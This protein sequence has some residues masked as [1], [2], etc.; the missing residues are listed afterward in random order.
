MDFNGSKKDKN[1]YSW[2]AWRHP[3]FLMC[4]ILP[5]CTSKTLLKMRKLPGDKARICYAGGP[6]FLNNFFLPS[7]KTYAA[8]QADFA[9]TNSYKAFPGI[10][11]GNLLIQSQYPADFRIFLQNRADI[12]A[13]CRQVIP[14]R[15]LLAL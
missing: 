14:P 8:R 7:R 2:V 10:R 4:R 12:P 1:R 11:Q 6:C 3:A 13:E 15:L 5:P 9:Q